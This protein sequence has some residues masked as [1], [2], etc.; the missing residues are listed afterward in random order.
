MYQLV[1]AKGLEAQRRAYQLAPG[2]GFANRVL[3]ESLGRLGQSAEANRLAD[4]AVALD[5]L[6][7]R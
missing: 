4:R 7:K 6:L 2:D 5:P 1:I 3:A